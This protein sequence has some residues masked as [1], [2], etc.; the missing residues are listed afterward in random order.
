MY[1]TS[2]VIK[3]TLSR[4]VL[5]V[6][7]LSDVKCDANLKLKGYSLTYNCTYTLESGVD[8]ICGSGRIGLWIGCIRYGTNL[9]QNS[10]GAL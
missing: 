10:L 3:A 2:I 4:V 6:T 9:Q 8:V 5:M 7:A 1:M